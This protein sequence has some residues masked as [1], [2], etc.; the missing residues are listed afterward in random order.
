MLIDMIALRKTLSDV[1][2]LLL[3]SEQNETIDQALLIVLRFFK[4]DRVY[5]GIFDEKDV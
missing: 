3:R 2:S 1:L 4:V 5:I